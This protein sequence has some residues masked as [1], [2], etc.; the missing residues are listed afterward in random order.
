MRELQTSVH[1]EGGMVGEFVGGMNAR[2]GDQ[3]SAIYAGL[4]LKRRRQQRRRHV[5]WA[6]QDARR[7]KNRAIADELLGPDHDFSDSEI[8]VVVRGSKKQRDRDRRR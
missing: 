6:H 1:A 8:A 2:L 5:T 4:M 7:A 3:L